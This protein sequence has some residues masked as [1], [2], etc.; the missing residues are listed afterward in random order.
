MVYCAGLGRHEA[1][2]LIE[3]SEKLISWAKY[4]FAIECLYSFSAALPRLSVLCL[5][6]RIIPY[7]IERRASY[8]LMTVIIFH[9]ISLLISSFFQC[10]PFR[11]HWDKSILGGSCSRQLN[12]YR[13]TS[14]PNIPI[15]VAI[16]VVPVRT[17]WPLKI[18]RYQKSVLLVVFLICNL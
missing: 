10:E 1:F 6:L 3:G 5:Y 15:D 13:W 11:Y 14:F 9:A 4:M 2:L 16:L 17:I 8:T 7:K 12:I 18:S